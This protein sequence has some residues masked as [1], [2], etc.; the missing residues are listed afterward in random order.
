[1]S[2]NTESTNKTPDIPEKVKAEYEAMFEAMFAKAKEEA[3]AEAKRIIEEAKKQ[4]NK[5][6]KPK[7]AHGEEEVSYTFFKDDG[8]YS[9][10]VYISVNGERIVCQRGVPVKI[11]RKFIWAFEQAQAQLKSAANVVSANERRY[12]QRIKEVGI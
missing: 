9:D 3:E 12:E 5:K 8:E 11:K 6:I 4:A 1:M 2:K 10:D 7:N